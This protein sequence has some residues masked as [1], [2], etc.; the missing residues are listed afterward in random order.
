M[1]WIL[2]AVISGAVY[3]GVDADGVRVF[4]DRPRADFTPKPIEA[5][6][7]FLP[8]EAPAPAEPPAPRERKRASRGR[9][10]SSS[11]VVDCERL[12]DRI[13][14]IRD[15]RRAGYDANRGRKLERDEQALR[16]EIRAQCR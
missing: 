4:T 5:V 1:K 11:D 16:R 2:L 6:N 9:D 10:Q 15:E 8:Y 14:L 13:R 12:Y 3:E 7:N